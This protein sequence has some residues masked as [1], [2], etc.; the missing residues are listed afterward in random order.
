MSD[1]MEGAW[2]AMAAVSNHAMVTAAP[3]KLSPSLPSPPIVSSALHVAAANALR[4]C[5]RCLC[6]VAACLCLDHV[7]SWV[8]AQLQEAWA[9]FDKCYSR[10]CHFGGVCTF[11][12]VKCVLIIAVPLFHLLL[13]CRLDSSCWIIL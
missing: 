12:V 8:C 6:F 4:Q 2:S 3:P 11:P 5:C 7:S 13:M 1:W 10:A 9:A